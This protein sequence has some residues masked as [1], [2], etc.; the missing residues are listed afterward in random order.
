MMDK[1]LYS[2]QL[3]T[4]GVDSMY[5]LVNSNVLFYGLD[6]YSTEIL[7]NCILCGVGNID[8]IDNN[9]I[10]Y[11]DYSSNFFV[12]YEDIGKERKIIINK[13][14]ELNPNV[15]VNI[16]NELNSDF[17]VIYMKYNLIVVI[18]NDLNFVSKINEICRNNNIKFIS[19]NSYYKWGNIFVDFGNHNII[20]PTNEDLKTGLIE[21]IN[22][23]IVYT[24]DKHNIFND[25]IIKI[26]D[27]EY[28]INIITPY[29]FKLISNNKL[30]IFKE[31]LYFYEIRKNLLV[32]H[33][34]FK[35]SCNK[36]SFINIDDIA[37]CEHLH[38][39]YLNNYQD[40]KQF[41]VINSILGGIVSQEIIKG[42]THKC[43]PIN[44][45]YYYNELDIEYDLNKIKNS[46][47]FIPGCG[48][49]GCELLKNLS[50][51]GVNII[52]SDMDKIEKSNLSRQFLF[53]NRH[54]NNFKSIIA[55]EMIK[56]YRSVNID[57]RTN[58]I[59]ETSEDIYNE[60]FYN[61]IDCIINAL[62]NIKTR[63][64]IDNKCLLFKKHLIDSGTLGLKGNTQ[65]IIPYLTESYNSYSNKESNE[66]PVCTIKTFP[67][68]T[69]HTL[70]WSK[71]IFMEYFNLIIQDYHNFIN[72]PN[73]INIIELSEK[74]N[75]I[76]NINY[77]I[78]NYPYTILD[79]IIWSVKLFKKLFID[80]ILELQNKYPLNHK[81]D[82]NTIFWSGNRKY[83]NIITFDIN[84]KNIIKFIKYTSLLW[85][86]SFNNNFSRFNEINCREL[87]E[88]LEL[89]N[90]ND[91]VNIDNYYSKNNLKISKSNIINI[92]IFDKDNDND[93]NFIYYCSSLRNINYN[94]QLTDKLNSK[95]IVG[96]I[97]PAISTTTSLIAGLATMEYIKIISGYKDI[98]YFKNYYVNLGQSLI[99][100]SQP[101]CVLKQLINDK[102]YS[103]WNTLYYPKTIILKDLILNINNYFNANL[104]VLSFKSY[105]IYSDIEETDLNMSL[106]DLL[107]KD[108]SL[109]NNFNIILDFIMDI[110]TNEDNISGNIYLI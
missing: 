3:Y 33:I 27:K 4:L 53:R 40:N 73:H 100:C 45:W 30:P 107:N 23:D 91:I 63:K 61:S 95:K 103:I 106:I 37:T 82:D 83:P 94:I 35:D 38:S 31:N 1:N 21:K 47:V 12:K 108:I 32:N 56:E 93:I 102:E 97:I 25:T 66:I 84:N 44:Q 20:D 104:E 13:L 80:D 78:D 11:V 105:I 110:E 89:N 59:D 8:I 54:I 50:V 88:L 55:K 43:I 6:S 90:L 2:R 34:N 18:N 71:N 64:Y 15:N 19:T 98:K 77:V 7:K 86:N 49:I 26:A 70:Q 75:Y 87:L 68:L 60:N 5:T 28:N 9:L 65:V 96:N 57:S 48:A 109:E 51:L 85:Y 76:N 72:N 39:L 29:S 42:V 22:N 46:R 69:E 14:K 17:D 74:D 16:I 92:N 52:T 41:I 79:S 81:N 67:Y 10:D 62:D 99:C 24:F 36:P 101:A 58:V